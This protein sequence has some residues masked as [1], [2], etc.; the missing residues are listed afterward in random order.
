MFWHNEVVARLTGTCF[1]AEPKHLPHGDS[2]TLSLKI[3]RRRLPA[4]HAALGQRPERAIH[5]YALAA[6]TLMGRYDTAGVLRCAEAA[7]ALAAGG[8]EQMQL[9]VYQLTA[10]F[11]MGDVRRL[12]ETGDEVLALLKPGGLPW[13]W[14]ASGLYNGHFLGG[15][16]AHAEHLRQALLSARPEAEARAAY[17]EALT[18]VLIGDGYPGFW[19]GT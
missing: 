13:C 2:G 10:L 1:I 14:L 17:L 8:P 5:Y 19:A 16:Q 9:R 12:F 3:A 6:G 15:S 18:S 11:W 7:L 4:E